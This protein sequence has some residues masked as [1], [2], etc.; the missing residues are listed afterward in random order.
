MT[1]A[2]VSQISLNYTGFAL[3][4]HE[5]LWVL[6]RVGSEV[7]LVSCG[8]VVRQCAPTAVAAP[9][10]PGKGRVARSQC[11]YFT[12]NGCQRNAVA[13]PKINGKW[14]LPVTVTTSV[15]SRAS[16]PT[17]PTEGVEDNA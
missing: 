2:R 11:L 14:Y 5:S 15:Q 3:S 16:I 7:C 13:Y 12:G 10:P 8:E 6:T 17:A 9:G 1:R 4:D